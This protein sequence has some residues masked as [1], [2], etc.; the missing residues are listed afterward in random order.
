MEGVI[1]DSR[2][3]LYKN[4][5]KLILKIKTVTG[6]IF[7]IALS[8]IITDVLIP[9]DL[10][11]GNKKHVTI[12]ILGSVEKIQKRLLRYRKVEVLAVEGGIAVLFPSWK[13]III[14]S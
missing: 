9:F 10:L 12:D 2:P 3:I 11:V 7:D 5:L 4:R 1:I 6:M 8:D 13:D 14:L